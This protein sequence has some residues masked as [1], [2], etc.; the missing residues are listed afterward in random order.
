ML[1]Y[2]ILSSVINIG[3]AFILITLSA[4]LLKINRKK[5]V[6]GVALSVIYT[7]F[8]VYY[9]CL[10][11]LYPHSILQKTVATTITPS[12]IIEY[13]EEKIEETGD[14][15][16]IITTED[17]TFSLAPDGELEIKKGIKFKI[18]KVVYSGNLENIK[19]DI[20]GFAG[21]ARK[22]DLQDIGYWVT[23]DDMIK[24]YMVK[25][26]KDKFEVEIKEGEKLIGTIYIKFVD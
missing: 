11:L 7:G 16:V 13:Q 1:D 25:G 20:R 22:N 26:E 14:F 21:N 5:F 19:A 6:Y 4:I 15:T 23:Y 24:R 2:V 17:N 8:A 9:L 3:I 12:N 10:V 18:E